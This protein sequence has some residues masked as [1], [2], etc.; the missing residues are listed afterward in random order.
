MTVE[1]MR[2]MEQFWRNTGVQLGKHWKIVMAVM[3]VITGVLAL[4]ATRIEFATGQDSYLNTDSQI[5]IDNVSFQD[6]FGG[7]TIILLFSAEEGVNVADLFVGDN[8]AELQRL[9]E[10][11]EQVPEVYSAITPYTS[12][13][14]SSALVGG[15]TGTQA[16][17][18]AVS[19][20][21]AGAEVRNEDITI[22]LARRG[23]VGPDSEWNIGNPA[24]NEVLIFDN[25][26]FTVN[27]A[28]EPVAPAEEDLVIRKSLRGT[29]PNVE[30]GTLNGTAVGGI[31]IEGNA[32]LDELTV[33]TDKVLEILDTAEFEGFELTI[34]GS[35]IYL[36]DINDYLQGGMLTLGAA[37]LV[38]MAIILALIFKVRWRLLPLLAVFVGVLWAFSLLG[39]MGIDLSLVTISGL[40]ILI[41][42][43]IDFAI[44]VHNRVEEEVVL[45]KEAHPIAE[46]LSNVAPPLIAATITGV[47][48]F[49]ALRISK[50]PMI[51]D[52]GVLLAVGVIVLVVVGIVLP[53]SLLGI[54]EFTKRTDEREESLV[55]KLV[56]KLGGL[57]TKAGLPLVVLATI[58]FVGGVLVEGRT[59]IQS[60]PVKWID[61]GSQTVSDIDRLAAETDFASTLGVLVAA[62]NVFDQEVVDL[63]FD[64]TVDAEA[65]DGVVASSS[66]VGTLEKIIDID[67]AN[68]IAPTSADIVNAATAAREETPAIARALVNEDNTTAQVNLRLEQASLEERAVLVDELAA[69]LDRR[70]AELDLPEDSILVTGLSAGQEPVKATPAGL[71]TVGIGLLENLK[72]N[73][74]NL[75]Y[76]ALVGAAL[77][78]VLRFRSLSRALL[79]LVPVLMAVGAS[80]LF[81]GLLGFELSPLTTVSG[82]LVIA[83]CAEF[84]VLIMGRYLE[85]RQAGQEPR[86]ATDKAASRTGRAF[87]T[88]AM[89]TIGGFAVLV[90][91]PLP[92]LRDFGIIVTLNVAIALLAAL[93]AMPPLLVWIDHKGLLGT[94]EQ[95]VDTAHSVR[96]AA[97]LPG[98]Q[99]VAAALGVVALI[100]AGIGVYATADTS[101]GESEELAFAAV[102]LPTTTTTTT[103]TVAP[104]PTVAGEDA[105]T[106]PLIDP[107]TF[108]DERPTSVVGGVLFDLLTDPEI[109]VA[110][111]V[112]NCA[113]ETVASRVSDEELLALGAAT[114]E[115]EAVAVVAQASLDCGITQNQIDRAVAKL[116]NEPL[117]P[118]EEPPVE[119][120]APPAE[121][122]IDLSGFSEERPTDLVPGTVFDLLVGGGDN[123]YVG[124]DIEPRAANCAIET[125]IADHG[126]TTLTLLAAADE[127]A[128]ANVKLSVVKCG[129]LAEVVDG[130]AAEF[131]AG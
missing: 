85:E 115:P 110:P 67:G 73:R 117:P 86:A 66:L 106:G 77:F 52:F 60:D 28:N 120:A 35:P 30:G 81:V 3:L 89:T 99:T 57:P 43:G 108:G 109:G 12:M 80:S 131:A 55:E 5:A 41:G 90:L 93:V 84:S 31:V 56:V 33:G 72:A 48:A 114:G 27:D 22:S 2:A 21:E 130:A 102:P 122:E 87:F 44:Q 70:I 14:Y 128:I 34:T 16:L 36:G 4:G 101:T 104:P 39:I 129:I 47:L 46:T 79:A 105:P 76:L 59:K 69:D 97:L 40:P 45:D 13:V 112:A 19:R 119:E 88:S 125:T 118:V 1:G 68:R 75:T 124:Q 116:R 92:L 51:R 71:A 37:A 121:P 74:A 38:V 98:K 126:D 25:T 123:N 58:L 62:N 10:E 24:W 100:A 94:Q 42:L 8:L 83:T 53:A 29:F 15:P 7:E 54:R 63:I 95:G 61:Q 49:L 18:G 6:D 64:F 78:L 103:T 107:S 111:N 32:T 26:G 17:A 65:R 96:L 82:P 91:S 23:A 9:T 113:I 50:V 11:I 20:D 127:T